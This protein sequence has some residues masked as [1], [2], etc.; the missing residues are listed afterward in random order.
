MSTTTYMI[1]DIDHPTHN[2]KE[3]RSPIE[4][5][6]G[7]GIVAEEVHLRSDTG[8]HVHILFTKPIPL[9]STIEA[10]ESIGQCDPAYIDLVKRKGKYLER[11]DIQHELVG[12]LQRRD[13]RLKKCH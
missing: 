10:L 1:V 8:V 4:R 11:T 7:E 3:L 13:E 6:L 5:I 12:F 2:I 9:E